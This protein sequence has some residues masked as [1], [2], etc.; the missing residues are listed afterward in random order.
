MA[1][2]TRTSEAAKMLGVSSRT[3]RNL[4]KKGAIEGV[5]LSGERKRLTWVRTES[6]E[7]FMEKR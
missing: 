3:F 2:L 6:L 1:Y 7:R 5:Q 4:V